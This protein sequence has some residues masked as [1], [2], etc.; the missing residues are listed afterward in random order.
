MVLA[1]FQIKDKLKKARFFQKMF[2]LANL[3]IKMVLEMIFLTLNDVNIQFVEKKFTWRSYIIVKA[4]PTI[5]QV[6]IIDK[7]AF[8]KIIL[9]KTV[10]IFVVYIIS[11]NLS[12]ISIYLAQKAQIALLIAKKVKISAKYLNLSNIF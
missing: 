5:K 8:A 4:L 10:E 12:L 9:D 6:E 3:N 7:K 11:F 1:S 2:L